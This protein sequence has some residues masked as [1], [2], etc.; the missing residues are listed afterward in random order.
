MS[1]ARD[2]ILGQIG[3]SLGRP[4]LADDVRTAAEQRVA[5]HRRNLVPQR[6]QKPH[7]EQIN[8]FAHWAEAH[9]ATAQRVPANAAIPAAV[10]D[11]LAQHNLPTEIRAAPHP[12]LDALPW[13]ERPLL[14]VKRGV[15]EITDQ[16]SL[17]PAFA[18]VAETGTLVLHSGAETPTTL[19]LVPDNHIVVLRASQIVGSYEDMWDRLRE[20][21]GERVMPRT[22][23][24]ITGPSRTGD[25]EQKMIL[26]AHG[27]RRLH[28]LIVDD[29]AA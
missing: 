13:H 2:H 7:A 12:D 17:T 22:V 11:Y 18:G 1:T 3:R 23:N 15:A 25:I 9:M 28:I 26:G 5:A 27:P 6:A 29:G 19:N 24:F 20:K 8:L 14:T 21:F 16:V 10:A 4:A